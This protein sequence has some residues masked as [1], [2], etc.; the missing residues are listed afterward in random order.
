MRA[1]LGAVVA[2]LVMASPALAAS[3]TE[4]VSSGQVTATLTYDYKKTQYGFYDF[5]NLHVTVDRAG[6]RLVD[7]AI[8]AEC[9][10]CSPWPAAGGTDTK[11]ISVRDLDSDGEPEVLLDLYSGGANCCYYTDAWYYDEASAKYA[12]VV[13][14]PGLDFFYTLKD[15]NHDGAPD[16]Y[17]QDYRFA[18]KYGSNADTPRPLQI[19]DWDS[20][21]LVDVTLSYPKLAARD[22]AQ[23]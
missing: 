10:Y 12:T 20:G 11:S 14:R 15:L 18:Y 16:F 13:L 2:L 6:Q 19:W 23:Y 17:S 9:Q 3:K 8:G 5:Q 7:Q 1:V 21:K 22:A 4:T